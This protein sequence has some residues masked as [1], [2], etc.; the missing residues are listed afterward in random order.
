MIY[1]RLKIRSE[2]SPIF[3][4]NSA[5]SFPRVARGNRTQPNVA[6]WEEINGDDAS[7]LRWRRILNVNVNIEIRSLVSEAPKHLKLAMTSRREAFSGNASLIATFSNF[8]LF[9]FIEDAIK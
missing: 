1:K 5:L 4:K 3:R 8:I 6:K 7:R 2:F 9:Y